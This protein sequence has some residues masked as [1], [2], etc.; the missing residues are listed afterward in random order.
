[1]RTFMGY[2]FILIY[3]SYGPRAELMPGDK[4]PIRLDVPLYQPAQ[5][6]FTLQWIDDGGPAGL[7]SVVNILADDC[8]PPISRDA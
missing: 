8:V 2:V 7:G 5:Q 6:Q 4:T 3:S 1:M